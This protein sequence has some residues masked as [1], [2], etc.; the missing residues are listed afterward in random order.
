MLRGLLSAGKVLALA[1]F[2]AIAGALVVYLAHHRNRPSQGKDRPRL[3]GRIAIFNNTRYV[4]EVQGRVRF[5][6]TAAVDNSY[7]DGTHE[8]EHVRLES[9]GTDGTRDDIVTADRAKISNTADLDKLQAEFLSNVSVVTTEALILKTSYLKYNSTKNTVE[10]PA[11]VWFTE[12]NME[13]KAVGMLIEAAEERVHLLKD[14]DVTLKPEAPTQQAPNAQRK[15]SGHTP[16]TATVPPHEPTAEEIAAR[17]ER[18]RARKLAREKAAESAPKET[19]TEKAVQ[20]AAAPKGKGATLAGGPKSPIHIT[21]NS[22]L[23]DKKQRQ[24]TFTGNVVVTQAV[25][26]LRADSMVA[27]LNASNQIERIE[28]RGNSDLKEESQG[29]VKSRDM[30][31]FLAAG[32]RLD[33]AVAT[34]GVYAQ[35]LGGTPAREAKGD[36]AEVTFVEGP[37]GNTIDTIKAAGHAYL[38]IHAPSPEASK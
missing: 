15:P 12:K 22:A 3:Q 9:H 32:Q 5:V 36:T 34:G 2:I 16:A 20:V 29:E 30:D 31:F 24:C 10:T 37:D 27:F 8:L 26:S 33:H 11:P 6:L 4:H 25:D 23:L 19:H 13:G 35:S 18:K 7:E 21:G 1:L 38:I 17:K 14:A 28:A